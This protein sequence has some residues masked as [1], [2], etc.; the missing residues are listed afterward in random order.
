MQSKNKQT[1]ILTPLSVQITNNV[2][3]TSD[4]QTHRDIYDQ[5]RQ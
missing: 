4:G 2:I 3:T 5:N 1:I